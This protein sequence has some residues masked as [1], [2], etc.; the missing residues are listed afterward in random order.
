M[1]QCEQMCKCASVCKS[2]SVC[3]CW[4]ATKKHSGVT[5]GSAT[6]T[7]Q[8]TLVC[9]CNSQSPGFSSSCR[10]HCSSTTVTK[11]PVTD[12]NK[13]AVDAPQTSLTYM[14]QLTCHTGITE[15][16]LMCHPGATEV[17]PAGCFWRH[18]CALAGGATGWC[19]PLRC[20]TATVKPRSQPA[21]RPCATRTPLSFLPLLLRLIL[22]PLPSFPFFPPK[23][24]FSI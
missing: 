19:A 17:H 1:H 15:L 12:N 3:H 13:V 21:D 24:R 14:C 2:A 5:P 9:R 23:Y 6:H 18:W 11:L 16:S 20:A 8:L 7:V 22:P 4:G 10:C